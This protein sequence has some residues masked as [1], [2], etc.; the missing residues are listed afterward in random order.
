M[1]RTLV[2]VATVAT[3]IEAMAWHLGNAL[4]GIK[5]QVDEDD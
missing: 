3:P 5:L 2:T 4:G 1:S